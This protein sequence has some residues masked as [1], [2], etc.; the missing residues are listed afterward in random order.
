MTS[1]P[2]APACSGTPYPVNPDDPSEGSDVRHDGPCPAHPTPPPGVTVERRPAEQY[3]AEFAR[4]SIVLDER[5]RPVEVDV[6]GPTSRFGEDV[7]A[8][9][10]WPSIGS[11]DA[12]SAALFAAG[13]AF[14]AALAPTLAPATG[15]AS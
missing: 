1:T 5:S 10:S 14:A 11:V 7:E 13:V 15:A 8:R 4:V 3:A 9:V 2:T 12:E 6:F